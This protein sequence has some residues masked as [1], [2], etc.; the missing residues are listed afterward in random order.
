MRVMS[1]FSTSSSSSSS[2]NSSSSTL[3]RSG[4][5]HAYLPHSGDMASL[6][7]TSQEQKVALTFSILYQ[8]KII[9]S[10]HS[11]IRE[12]HPYLILI[13]SFIVPQNLF[14]MNNSTFARSF[15]NFVF[16]FSERGLKCGVE[17]AP[18][19]LLWRCQYEMPL[20]GRFGI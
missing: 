15:V 6:L 7:E 1:S 18:Q 12:K 17:I 11:E 20:M 19:R 5:N 9:S 10:F 14:W 8:K 3:N 2:T 4:L 16:L 13:L